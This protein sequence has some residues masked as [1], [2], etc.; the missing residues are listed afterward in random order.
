MTPAD[1]LWMDPSCYDGQSRSGAQAHVLEDPQILAVCKT[2]LCWT[3]FP[4]FSLY[5]SKMKVLLCGSEVIPVKHWRYSSYRHTL[6]MKAH[7]TWQEDLAVQRR[8]GNQV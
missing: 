1:L 2:G 4:F 6:L 7:G 8:L 5:F 3:Y